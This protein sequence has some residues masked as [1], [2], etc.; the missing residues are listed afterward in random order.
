MKNVNEKIFHH[1]PTAIFVIIAA[2]SLIFPVFYFDS[3]G[4]RLSDVLVLTVIPVIFLFKPKIP[5]EKIFYLYFLFIL[6][7]IF[8]L[9]YGYSFLEVPSSYRDLSE[10]IRI[11]APVF[12]MLAM[13]NIDR[14]YLASALTHFMYYGS[15]F[16]LLIATI[17]YFFI[18][19]IGPFVANLYNSSGQLDY[20]IKYKAERI[21]ITGSD[22]NVGAAIV[23]LFLQFNIICFV[24][25]KNFISIFVSLLLLLTLFLTGSRTG[26]VAFIVS[27]FIILL[28]TNVKRKAHNFLLVFFVT[29][30]MLFV[31]PRIP[32][33]YIGFSTLFKGTNNS[34][35]V[36]LQNISDVI[37]LFK[38]SM[39]FGWG[40]AKVIHPTGVD[41]EY[42]LLL[43]RYGLL[44][45]SLVFVL[46]LYNVI[47]ILKNRVLLRYFDINRSYLLAIL[48]ISYAVSIAVIMLT[49]NFISGYQLLLPYMLIAFLVHLKITEIK[50]IERKKL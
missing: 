35:L 8:S 7:T 48:V 43:R 47:R 40:P 6:F 32:Y 24:V 30:L 17:Q 3:L 9:F 20:Y 15:F 16:I 21:F 33:I 34:V 22:P 50:K 11:S 2:G 18:D 12:L 29:L 10:I 44:G 27:L 28:V 14:D 4:F 23:L 37:V 31:I 49:N 45:I 5:K 26:L 46:M 36:R 25:K 1:L 13:L 41:G 42:F 39:F 19:S 38:Q